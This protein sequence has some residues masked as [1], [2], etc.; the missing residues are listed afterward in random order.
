MTAKKIK[1]L[2][3]IEDDKETAD[4]ITEALSQSGWQIEK[5]EEGRGALD[6]LEAI[7]PDIIL[8]DLI[9][10]KMDGFEVLKRLRQAKRFVK[11]IIILSNLDS[12]EDIIKGLE[13]GAD[14][15]IIKGRT[16]MKEFKNKLTAYR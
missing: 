14:D 6:R 7:K 8:L 12:S 11:P 13:L 10:P 3:L 9:L 5:A 2:L 16:S 4:T 15:Y 1:T